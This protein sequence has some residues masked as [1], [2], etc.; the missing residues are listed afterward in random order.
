MS[1][2]GAGI[3][4]LIIKNNKLYMVTFIDRNNMAS[5]A[6][7]K[8]ESFKIELDMEKVVEKTALRELYEESSGLIKISDLTESVYYE[9]KNYGKIYRLYFII[10]NKLNPKYYLTNLKKFNEFKLNPFNEM[11]SI[12]LLDVSTIKFIDKNIMINDI[13]NISIKVSNRL[14]FVLYKVMRKFKTFENFYSSLKIKKITLR[15]KLIKINSEEYDTK[16]KFKVDN[17]VCYKS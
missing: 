16:K 3:V 1:Y 5:D 14:K 6:G 12:K 11:Y 10:I 15:K 9:I 7:G 8:V 2:S 17:I 4:P 13:D